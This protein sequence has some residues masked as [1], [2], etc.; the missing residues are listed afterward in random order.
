MMIYLKKGK[1]P[2]HGLPPMKD[3]R[4]RYDQI[5]KKKFETKVE[6]LITRDLPSKFLSHM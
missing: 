6:D 4:A 3:R 5:V 2:W 1:L